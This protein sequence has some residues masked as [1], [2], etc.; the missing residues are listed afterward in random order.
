MKK[1][2]MLCALA[3][4]AGSISAL[5]A[6]DS[7]NSQGTKLKLGVGMI[8][9]APEV[10]YGSYQLE[11]NFAAAVWDA[12]NKVVASLV[13]VYQVQLGEGGLDKSEGK[14]SY[15][16]GNTDETKTK[17]DRHD[18]YN[19]AP[20]AQKGE[21][22]VQAENLENWTKGKEVSQLNTDNNPKDGP[23]ASANVSINTGDLLGAV[24]ESSS[25]YHVSEAKELSGELTL[26]L[27]HNMTYELDKDTKQLTQINASILAVVLNKD[28]VIQ[29]AFLDEIQIPVVYTAPSADTPSKAADD[30]ENQAKKGTWALGSAKQVGHDQGQP[31][32]SKKEMHADYG[33]SDKTLAPQGDWYEQAAKFENYLVGKKPSDVRA[34]ND[35]K[36]AA[37]NVSISTGTY[38]AALNNAVNTSLYNSKKI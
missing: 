4:V 17:R 31:V 22:Y 36:L 19:M 28:N 11:L 15:Y 26:A 24:K 30:Q 1:A 34:D 10:S 32:S 6:C 13:D 12:D 37:A 33:M 7:N 21:W 25:G 29:Q 35:G 18:D 38:F 5:A 8:S 9:A 2:K 20:V 3:L 27:G 16:F 14:A 23:V